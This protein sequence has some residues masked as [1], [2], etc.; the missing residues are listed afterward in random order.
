[1]PGSWL[2]W[3]ENTAW[4]VAIRQSVWLYPALEIMHL[5]GIALLAGGAFLFDLRLLGYGKQLPVT[6]LARHLLCWARRGLLLVV[7][8]GVMLF[9]AHA[10]TLGR[11][12]VF[13]IKMGNLVLAG[14]NAFLFHRFIFP[15]AAAWQQQGAPS[16][17]KI[18]AICS[19]LLWATVIACGRLLAY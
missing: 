12:P 16:G 19:L 13:W 11:D 7:L 10:A 9:S 14:G 4:A 6:T 8:S 17:A 3:L 18:A 1:M 5:T 15:S 2:H